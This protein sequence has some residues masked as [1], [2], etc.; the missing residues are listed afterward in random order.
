MFRTPYGLNPIIDFQSRSPIAGHAI[1]GA[2]RRS[3][4]HG[5]ILAA[6]R[7]AFILPAT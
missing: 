2:V 4:R 7:D 6:R 5:P 1:V 3:D